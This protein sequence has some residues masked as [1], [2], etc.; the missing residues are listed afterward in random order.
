MALIRFNRNATGKGQQPQAK[1]LP[2]NGNGRFIVPSQPR[3][4]PDPHPTATPTP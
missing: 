4:T 1:I 2:N 3:A